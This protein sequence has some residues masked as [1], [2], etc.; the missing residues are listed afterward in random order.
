MTQ[1]RLANKAGSLILVI[2]I[3]TYRSALVILTFVVLE[4]K[5]MLVE[6]T[7]FLKVWRIKVQQRGLALVLDELDEILGCAFVTVDFQFVQLTVQRIDLLADRRW[8][9]PTID[10]VLGLLLIPA[11]W[12]ARLRAQTRVA[13]L[14]N[15][16]FPKPCLDDHLPSFRWSG[17]S[18]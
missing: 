17:H 13:D 6:G 16:E 3:N 7:S 4:D 10:L 15:C 11:E 9:P 12:T 18:E 2:R 8:R 14:M 1:A 5:T